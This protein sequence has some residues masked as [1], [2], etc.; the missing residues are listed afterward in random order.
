MSQ[1]EI[2]LK[3]AEA[4]W[5]EAILL[6][7]KS[8]ELIDIKDIQIA[9]LKN[10][11]DMLQRQLFSS[12]KSSN[13]SLLALTSSL[14][15]MQQSSLKFASEF[16]QFL[17]VLHEEDPLKYRNMVDPTT[18]NPIVPESGTD[19]MIEVDRLNDINNRIKVWNYWLNGDRSRNDFDAKSE[20]INIVSESKQKKKK[21]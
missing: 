8:Q 14:D 21:K 4:G 17:Q 18:I 15:E 1:L 9:A 11:N 10:E 6:V 12:M 2:A 5:K 20:N 7:K 3:N 19:I 13:A 16:R